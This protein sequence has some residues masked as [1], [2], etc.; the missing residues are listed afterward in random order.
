MER[1]SAL[2]AYPRSLF[3]LVPDPACEATS[4]IDPIWLNGVKELSC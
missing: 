1:E 3:R 2:K 4:E